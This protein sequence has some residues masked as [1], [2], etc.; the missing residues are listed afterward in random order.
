[1]HQGMTTMDDR[2]QLKTK[3][4]VAFIEELFDDARDARERLK[5]ADDDE[6]KIKDRITC[7]KYLEDIVK[8]YLLLKKEATDDPTAAGATVRKYASAFSKNAAGSGKKNTRRRTPEPEPDESDIGG[9]G[10]EA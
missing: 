7:L 2:P 1:M 4:E 9:D 6:C 10:G 3:P 8:T 5:E